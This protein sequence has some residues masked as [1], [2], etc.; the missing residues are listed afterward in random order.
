MLHICTS[1][2]GSAAR[3]SVLGPL[4]TGSPSENTW[5]LMMWFCGCRTTRGGSSRLMTHICCQ[6]VGNLHHISWRPAH[7]SLPSMS[8]ETGWV[9]FFFF[10]CARGITR[11]FFCVADG[12]QPP[13]TQAT[14]NQGFLKMQPEAQARC[15]WSSFIGSCRMKRLHVVA[16]STD[17]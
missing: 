4:L 15:Y 10:F 17:H 14:E 12:S 11:H 13:A 8:Q 3:A 7:V 16:A 6:L 2:Q 1:W 5:G 9:F